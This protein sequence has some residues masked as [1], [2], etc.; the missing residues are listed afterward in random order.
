[1]RKTILTPEHKLLVDQLRSLRESIPLTQ[2]ELATRLGRPQ[3]F[4]SKY[5]AGQR[6]VDVVELAEI[7]VALDS[8]LAE[9][10]A[11]FQRVAYPS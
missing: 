3:S 4:V 1:M 10:V 8:D 7:C 9:F 5:E 11:R 6:R 2:R